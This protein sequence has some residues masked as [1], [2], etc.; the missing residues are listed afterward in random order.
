[1]NLYLSKATISHKMNNVVKKYLFVSVAVLLFF[2]SKGQDANKGNIAIIN[3]IEMYYEIHGTGVP[4]VLLHGFFGSGEWWDFV[5]EDF[6]KQYQLIIP[7]LRG[8]GRSINPLEKWSMA[9]SAMDI[10]ALLDF[11][12]IDKIN[13]IGVS[14]GGKTLLHMATQDS[15]RMKAMVL[16]GGTM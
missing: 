4:L 14:T 15:K 12:G 10:Y 1:M 6:S 3:G 16:I 8:H 7:D 11:L 5:I 13:G 9:Q 2:P